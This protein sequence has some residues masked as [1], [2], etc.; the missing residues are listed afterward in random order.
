MLYYLV[1]LSKYLVI[2]LTFLS[3]NPAV[4]KI[5]KKGR[6]GI[7]S[8]RKHIYRFIL[9]ESDFKDD[10]YGSSVFLSLLFHAKSLHKKLKE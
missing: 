1:F 4:T 7:E 5:T 10:S 3:I 9:T 6:K 2:F 8:R